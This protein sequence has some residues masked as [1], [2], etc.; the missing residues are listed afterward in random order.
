MQGRKKRFTG[1][2]AGVIQQFTLERFYHTKGFPI[3]QIPKKYF[4][5]VF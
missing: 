4:K 3:T 5:S 1:L 2:E